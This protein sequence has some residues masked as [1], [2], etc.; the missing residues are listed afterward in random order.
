[1]IIGKKKFHPLPD[2]VTAGNDTNWE[3]LIESKIE[4]SLKSTD[5]KESAQKRLTIDLLEDPDQYIIL[6]PIPGIP[7]EN[8]NIFLDSDVVTIYGQAPKE[9]YQ[10]G[11][12]VYQ[13]CEWGEF[14]RSITLPKNIKKTGHKAKIKNG[15]L[16]IILSKLKASPPKKINIT[17][18]D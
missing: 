15:L 9:C 12:P 14:S 18:Y 16:T 7:E 11:K 17:S 1:M 6:T 8:I 4:L 3:K 5:Q 2:E 10:L 13:E